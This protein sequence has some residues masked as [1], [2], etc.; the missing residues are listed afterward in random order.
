MAMNIY[1]NANGKDNQDYV[2]QSLTNFLLVGGWA[3]QGMLQNSPDWRGDISSL[4]NTLSLQC[5]SAGKNELHTT[6]EI[7]KTAEH[8]KIASDQHLPSEQKDHLRAGVDWLTDFLK[9]IVDDAF[10]RF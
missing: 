2:R 6:I 10:L 9:W 5:K 3:A 1:E 7:W 8:C 4:L